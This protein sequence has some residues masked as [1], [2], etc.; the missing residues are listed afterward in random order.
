MIGKLT[1]ILFINQSYSSLSFGLEELSPSKMFLDYRIGLDSNGIFSIVFH[2]SISIKAG[3]FLKSGEDGIYGRY[4]TKS[5]FI[6]PFFI[7]FYPL[8]IRMIPGTKKL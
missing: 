4:T 7:A 1:I 8:R 3:C 6:S 2:N 5:I